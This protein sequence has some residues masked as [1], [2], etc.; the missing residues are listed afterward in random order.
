MF[1]TSSE[2]GQRF[3]LSLLVNRRETAQGPVHVGAR[4]QMLSQVVVYC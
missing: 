4:S 1:P 2:P 3:A